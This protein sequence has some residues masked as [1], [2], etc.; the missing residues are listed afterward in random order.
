[1]A[2]KIVPVRRDTFGG[3]RVGE[4]VELPAHLDA[5]MSGDRY[6]RISGFAAIH[7]DGDTHNGCG[8]GVALVKMDKS[9][10][11]IRAPLD[12]LRSI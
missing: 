6:G 5:W 7:R 10:R 2:A 3:R 8:V 9:G 12:G 1:M 4:R 11:T